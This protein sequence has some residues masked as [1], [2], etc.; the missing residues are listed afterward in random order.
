MFGLS[1]FSLSSPT[2]AV[3]AFVNLPWEQKR[4]TI[5]KLSILHFS[6]VSSQQVTNYQLLTSY[7]WNSILRVSAITQG[8]TGLLRSSA[9]E[10]WRG[11]MITG[12]CLFNALPGLCSQ[13]FV[14]FLL[15]VLQV[16]CSKCL[17][18][19]YCSLNS[20]Q[21]YWFCWRSRIGFAVFYIAHSDKTLKQLL[22]FVG[23]YME[24]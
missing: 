21:I 11:E 12:S 15:L 4:D 2:L 10:Q 5:Q 14:S 1:A 8:K 18:W 22:R 3:D 23:D 16:K 6:V 9:L 24:L 17:T 19:G 13:Q 7:V 20:L